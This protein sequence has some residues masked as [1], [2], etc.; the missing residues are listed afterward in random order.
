MNENFQACLEIVLEYEGGLS[1]NPKDPG[2][3][4]NRGITQRVY[5]AY[6]I[7][8]S[9]HTSDVLG[10]TDAELEFIYRT[11]YWDAVKG[12]SLP[13]GVDLVMFDYAVNSGAAQA[14][15]DLQRV[16]GA[17]VDG[18][19]GTATLAGVAVKDNTAIINGV[20][21]ARL[22][23]MRGLKTWGTFGSGWGARVAGVQHQALVMNGTQVNAAPVKALPTDQAK[24][25]T[26]EG[27]GLSA[28]AIGASGTAILNTAQQIQ[29][30]IADTML[31]KLA[32]GVFLLIGLIGGLLI[33]YSYFKR[34]KEA[35]GLG[36][37]LTGL[38]GVGVG[39]GS[40]AGGG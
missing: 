34:A 3:R 26:P 32:L 24:L 22:S 9:L 1:N 28:G 5:D 8:Q 39:A 15:K 35:G 14:A 16:L 10:I 27:A 23:F 2:G 18:I 25:K 21:A 40:G 37:F 33:A 12:Y 19:V 4:T 6:R 7:S 36:S 11:Q 31:G 38:G 29:P 20:C 17:P 30:H 13:V